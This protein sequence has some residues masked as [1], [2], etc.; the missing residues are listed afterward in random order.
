MVRNRKDKKKAANLLANISISL[1]KLVDYLIKK[2]PNDKRIIRLKKKFNSLNI[3]ESIS[4]TKYT[5]YSVNKGEK[6][7]FCLRSKVDNS[8]IDLNTLMFV[9]LHEFAHMI[10]KDLG[11]TPQFW[12]N[13]EYLINKAV[14]YKLYT[15]V[16]Y[17]SNPKKLK[18]IIAIPGEK[19]LYNKKNIYINDKI[20][21]QY[22]IGGTTDKN[23]NNLIL[24]VRQ[25]KEFIKNIKLK[26]K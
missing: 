3:S 25:K 7:V 5:S 23:H 19:I 6:I 16:D 10:T 15:K 2:F 24:H 17:K 8:L 12:K 14:K 18:R 13:F 9:A 4:G 1:D 11:H 20:Q 26:N 22:D 21:K